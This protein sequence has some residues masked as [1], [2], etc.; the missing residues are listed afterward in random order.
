MVSIIAG[1]IAGSVALVGFGIDSLIEVASAAALL[2]RLYH[3]F[4]P[5]RREQVERTTLR[6]VGWCF[7][8][9]PLYIA[10]ESVSTLIRHEAPEQS[11]P[12]ITPPPL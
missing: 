11:I 12:G 7:I 10:Y 3:D 6:M 1:L 5:S 4:N 9:L 2:W 8:A